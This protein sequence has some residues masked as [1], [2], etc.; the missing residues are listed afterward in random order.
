[1]NIR[2]ICE[3]QRLVGL[4]NLLIDC[5]HF[6]REARGNL[7]SVILEEEEEEEW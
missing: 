2:E 1:M 6:L 7:G 5:V 3:E 4:W